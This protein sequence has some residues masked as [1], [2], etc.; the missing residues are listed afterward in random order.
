LVHEHKLVISRSKM[1]RFVLALLTS[2]S[3]RSIA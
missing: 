1:L 3:T 2:S